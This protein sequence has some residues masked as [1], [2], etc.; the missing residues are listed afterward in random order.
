MSVQKWDTALYQEKHNFVWK[1]GES[2]IEL[3]SPQP[4]ER[5][6]DLGCGAG[7]LTQQI[8]EAGAEVIG[9]DADATMIRQAQQNYPDL[10]FEVTD[11]RNFQVTQLYDA[12]FSNAVL[13]WVQQPEPVIDCIWR[14]LKPG[15]RFVVEFGGRGNVQQIVDALY[16][17]LR[18]M[19]RSSPMDL[20]PWYFP[21]LG[22]YATLLENQGFRVMHAA[23]L[24][25]PTPLTDGM[26]GLANW[27]RMFANPFLTELSAQAQTELIRGVEE[28]LKP[29]LYQDGGWIADYRRLRLAALKD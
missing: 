16:E 1:Y 25:R 11:A 7:Q 3:L 8:A 27:L 22:E 4:G 12:V 2:L 6:L 18:S 9:L 5:I 13:H 19:G 17:V 15:G 20:N 14:S 21:S 24:D 26:A 10:Q 29:S 28:R 23:L